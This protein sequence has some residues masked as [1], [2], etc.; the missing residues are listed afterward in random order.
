TADNPIALWQAGDDA[1]ISEAEIA[2]RL[3]MRERERFVSYPDEEG[4]VVTHALDM[5]A[6][7]AAGANRDPGYETLAPDAEAFAEGTVQLKA[8][9]CT[10]APGRAG[11]LAAGRAG[12]V[13]FAGNAT[14]G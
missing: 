4:R 5:K 3:E 9:C 2:A 14:G 10:A 13:V 1:Y 7:K 8:D 11:G 12:R 6:V